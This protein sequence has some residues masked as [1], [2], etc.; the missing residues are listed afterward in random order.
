MNDARRGLEE[1]I[2]D[3]REMSAEHD[4]LAQ[5]DHAHGDLAAMEWRRGY[6]SGLDL[7]AQMLT[8]LSVEGAPRLDVRRLEQV[9]EKWR[10]FAKHQHTVATDDRSRGIWPYQHE[11]AG[12]ARTFTRCADELAALLAAGAAGRDVQP[13]PPNHLDH[14]R[15]ARSGAEAGRDQ[16]R[17]ADQV[18]AI[19]RPGQP[20]HREPAGEQSDNGINRRPENSSGG[21]RTLPRLDDDP[22]PAAGRDVPREPHVTRVEV[23]DE[24]GRRFARWNCSAELSYQDEGRTLKVF[25]AP[26]ARSERTEP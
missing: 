14:D 24:Y 25:L 15:D 5:A 21:T 1:V 22:S 26:L 9:V 7:A 13:E 12:A 11:A 16:N 17:R 10:D 20:E 8:E 18:S 6:R 2:A 3:L 19:E 23:I 4:R